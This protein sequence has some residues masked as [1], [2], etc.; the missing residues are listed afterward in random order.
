MTNAVLIAGNAMVLLPL[1]VAAVWVTWP[2]FVTSFII[3]E[4]RGSRESLSR[5]P[6]WIMKSMT[7]LGFLSLAAQGAA[8]PRLPRHRDHTASEGAGDRAGDRGRLAAAPAEPIPKPEFSEPKKN[9]MNHPPRIAQWYSLA[10]VVFAGDQTAKTYI[11]MTTPLGWSHEVTSFFNLVHV[12][13][14]GAAFSFPA[15]AGG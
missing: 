1:C 8:L 5:F 3:G 2:D 15:G 9:L 12:L 13:N 7:P 6:A 14:P 4:T 11:E 10:I